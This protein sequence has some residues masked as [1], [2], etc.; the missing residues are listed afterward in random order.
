M[1]YS[2]MTEPRRRRL[3]ADPDNYPLRVK[4][5]GKVGLLSPNAI[6]LLI[7]RGVDFEVDDGQ[8]G[9][10]LARGGDESA[11]TSA[12][13]AAQP[14]DDLAPP[15]GEGRPGSCALWLLPVVVVAGLIAIGRRLFSRQGIIAVLRWLGRR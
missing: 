2:E 13:P 6:D 3:L 5:L 8:A 15:P 4:F 12:P 1:R 14:S 9:E 11:R 7:A 10:I